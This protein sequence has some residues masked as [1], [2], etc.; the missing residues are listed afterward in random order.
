MGKSITPSPLP[1]PPLLV[2]EGANPPE[3]ATQI[4]PIIPYPLSF[5]LSDLSNLAMSAETQKVLNS[6]YN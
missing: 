5:M 2:R 3:T 1:P 4:R 6:F